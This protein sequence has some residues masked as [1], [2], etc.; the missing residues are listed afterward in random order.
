MCLKLIWVKFGE[1]YIRIDNQFLWS[2]SNNIG[3]NYLPPVM[4]CFVDEQKYFIL[5]H[6]DPLP[7]LRDVLEVVD[8][9]DEELFAPHARAAAAA[10]SAKTVVHRVSITAK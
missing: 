9:A 2:F 1:S 7:L 10:A 8:D 5:L 3:H 6:E 4:I